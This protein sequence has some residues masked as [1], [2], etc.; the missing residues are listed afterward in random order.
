MFTD[1]IESI[2]SN[3][4]ENIGGKYLILKRIDTVNWSW[5]CDEEKIHTNKLNK[6]IY[7]PEPQFNILSATALYESIKDY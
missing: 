2:V 6:V 5:N 3:G 7:F 1:K 4:V